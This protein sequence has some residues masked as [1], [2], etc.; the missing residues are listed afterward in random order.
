MIEI[1]RHLGNWSRLEIISRV[2]NEGRKVRSRYLTFRT[3]ESTLPI[4]PRRSSSRDVGTSSYRYH[5]ATNVSTSPIHTQIVE[6]YGEE[7]MSRQRVAK[8]CHSF[9]SGTHGIENPKMAGSGRP[10]SSKGE[11]NSARIEEMI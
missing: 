3:N 1:A 8:W 7:A 2:T 9:Q 5:T 4:T 10:S 6:V 11:I